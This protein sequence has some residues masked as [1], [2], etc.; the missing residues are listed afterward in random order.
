[1]VC[2]AN[3]EQVVSPLDQSGV[4]NFALGELGEKNNQEKLPSV[5]TNQHSVI[6]P[7]ML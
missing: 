1:M 7:S 3:Q 6:L 4:G 5:S 2:S